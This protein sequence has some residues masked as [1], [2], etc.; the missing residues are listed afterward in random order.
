[1]E[2]KEYMITE[3]A[4][5]GYNNKVVV[6]N[7]NIKVRR[8]EILSI[9]GPNGIGKSTILKSICNQLAP[10]SGTIMLDKRCIDEYKGSELAR[11]L[12]V[13]MTESVNPE[14]Y[15]CYDVVALGRYP[16][17]GR[18]GALSDNDRNIINESMELVGISNLSDMYFN[19]LSDGQKQRAMLARAICQ[20]PDIL[21]LDEPTAYLDIKYKLELL[22]I[23][24]YLADTKNVAICMTL[25]EIDL[26]YKVSDKV[27]CIKDNDMYRYGEPE[28]ILTSEYIS[29]LYDIKKGSYNYNAGSVELERAC[30]KP[31]VF[32]IGGNGSGIT[33]YRRLNRKRIPF[34]AGVLHEN[35]AEYQ[36]AKALATDVVSESAFEYISAE[37]IE[38]AKKY[39]DECERVYACVKTFG[40]MNKAN[41]ELIAYARNKNKLCGISG[42]NSVNNVE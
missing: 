7:I 3:N 29:E 41:L 22:S 11:K 35:D 10:L 37:H 2:D 19:T 20:E 36:I 26:A 15:T 25:H 31:K 9:I 13:L 12:S 32:V 27:L 23:L 17:T 33:L 4:S 21:I 42:N 14:L 5:F 28:D 24:K 40:N 38:K 16:Y 1:M 6:G 30:G 18:M 34:A 39:I 8:G